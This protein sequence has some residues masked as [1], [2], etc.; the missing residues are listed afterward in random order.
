M[1]NATSMYRGPKALEGKGKKGAGKKAKFQQAPMTALEYFIY[2]CTVLFVAVFAVMQGVFLYK[3]HLYEAAFDGSR[4]MAAKADSRV[5]TQEV[6][7]ADNAG[8]SSSSSSSAMAALSN[9][10][11]IE[12][13]ANSTKREFTKWPPLDAIVDD[14]DGKVI[15]NPQFLLDFG[16]LGFEKSGKRV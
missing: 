9:R 11:R 1:V 3:L 2:M 4:E 16:I 5:L 6:A 13:M 7:L 14:K 8:G 15:G 10:Q 12:F